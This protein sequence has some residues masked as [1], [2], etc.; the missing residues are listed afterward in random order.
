MKRQ[1]LLAMFLFPII[2]SGAAAKAQIASGGAF[3][4]QQSVNA[5]GGE[6]S[7][8]GA[9]TLENTT[10]QSIAA[11]NALGGSFSIHAGFWIPQTFAPTAANVTVGGR[12]LTAD[13][14]GIRNALVTLTNTSGETRTTITGTFGYYRFAEVEAGATYIVSVTSKRFVFSNSSQVVNIDDAREDI[15]FTADPQ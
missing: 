13:G 10:G 8:N 2:F 12:V 7:A 11:Q 14:S 1:I 6:K 4:L 15:N 3:T 5:S 9:F